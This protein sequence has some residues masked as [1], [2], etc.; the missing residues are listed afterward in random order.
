MKRAHVVIASS[1]PA[2]YPG[3]PLELSIENLTVEKQCCDEY[4]SNQGND[5]WVR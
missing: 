3:F 2:E 1:E 4:L 5:Q